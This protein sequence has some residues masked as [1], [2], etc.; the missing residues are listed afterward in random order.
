MCIFSVYQ[1]HPWAVG[2]LNL[3]IQLKVVNPI[4]GVEFSQDSR[5]RSRDEI[6][7]TQETGRGRKQ[8]KRP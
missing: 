7:S 1:G 2:L 3:E 4:K 8:T 5:V 6:A